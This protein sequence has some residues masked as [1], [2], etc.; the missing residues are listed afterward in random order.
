LLNLVNFLPVKFRHPIFYRKIEAGD[1]KSKYLEYEKVILK[2]QPN[3]RSDD[4][5]FFGMLLS[6]IKELPLELQAFILQD[7]KGKIENVIIPFSNGASE[8]ALPSSVESMDQALSNFSVL[9]ESGLS[10]QKVIQSAIKRFRS[11]F[12]LEEQNNISTQY[13]YAIDVNSINP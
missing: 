8:V 7:N 5:K 1:T 3:E 13:N 11:N 12:N 4:K 10:L 6:A 2:W 9:N